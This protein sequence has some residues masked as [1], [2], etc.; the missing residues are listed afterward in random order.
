M[1]LQLLNMG[2]TLNTCSND[3]HVGE[4][5]CLL[6]IIKERI[7]GTYNTIS[8][9]KF[10]GRVIVELVAFCIFWL[11][12]LYPSRSIADGLSPQTII[13]G[14]TIDYNKHVKH[15]FGKY[16]QTHEETDN[17][18]QTRTIGAISLR[19]TGNVQGRHFYLSLHTG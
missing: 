6:Q 10:P 7:C 19:P 2:I 17:C 12:S 16:V 11:K 13:T 15:E 1:K 3:E 8:F 14:L 9:K 4:I 5:E 18:M